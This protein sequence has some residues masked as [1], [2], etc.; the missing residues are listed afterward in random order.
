MASQAEVVEATDLTLRFKHTFYTFFL[1]VDASMSCRRIKNSLLAIL[2]ERYPD[3]LPVDPKDP[4]PNAPRIPLPASGHDIVFG[5][6]RSP[7]DPAQGF[8]ELAAAPESSFRSLGIEDNSV[9]AFAFLSAGQ[10]IEGEL[11]KVNFPDLEA[12]YGE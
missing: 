5:V 12:L 8:D 4:L 11:F 9:L 1:F 10:E 3:G 7:S 2:S 6:P